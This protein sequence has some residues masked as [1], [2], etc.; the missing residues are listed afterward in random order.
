MDRRRLGQALLGFSLA[1]MIA[2]IPAGAQGYR[3]QP[4]D[5][6]FKIAQRF[7]TTVEKL[8]QANNLWTTDE[9]WA[10][11]WLNLPAGLNKAHTVKPGETLY[12]IAQR[13]GITVTELRRLNN[14]WNSSE[15]WVGQVLAVPAAGSGSPPPPGNGSP[16]SLDLTPAEI[17]LLSRLVTAEAEGEDYA[18]Q[19]AVAATV[20][21]RVKDPRF[22]NTV[23]GVIYQYVNGIPQFSPVD[24]GRIHLPATPQARQAV[25]DALSGS[26]PSNGALGFFNPE[27][28]SNQWVRAQPVTASIGNHLFFTLR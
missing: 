7:E 24:D 4:G 11:A 20:L 1:F 14:I 5:S 15:I 6:L 16:P 9:I 22:P 10:G 28:T 12:L 19:V 8:R 26:D 3:I 17:D 2:A 18:G 23:E 21:N 25:L 13:Y 27:K